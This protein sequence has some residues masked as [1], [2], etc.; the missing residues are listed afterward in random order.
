MSLS[1]TP[2]YSSVMKLGKYRAC[3][4]EG[5]QPNSIYDTGG[6]GAEHNLEKNNIAQG[7][8]TN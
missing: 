8:N 1:L 3:K 7:H 5:V 2:G 4:P 6:K